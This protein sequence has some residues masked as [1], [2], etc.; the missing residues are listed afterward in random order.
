M[1]VKH[2]AVALEADHTTASHWAHSAV[3]SAES[4]LAEVRSV[5][6]LWAEDPLEVVP[7]EAASAAAHWVQAPSAAALSEAVLWAVPRASPLL[8][9]EQK[10]LRHPRSA[11]LRQIHL[12]RLLSVLLEKKRQNL[13]RSAHLEAK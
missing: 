13:L 1:A 7:L 11:L 4:H 12:L 9:A 5:A 8:H 3:V 10:A 6:D 2:S